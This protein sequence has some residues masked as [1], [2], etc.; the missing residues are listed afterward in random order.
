[1]ASQE[2]KDNDCSTCKHLENC[3]VHNP[4][5]NPNVGYSCIGYEREGE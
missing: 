3:S 5:D 2:L 4:T 1:M